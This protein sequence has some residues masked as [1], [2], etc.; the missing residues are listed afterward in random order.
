MGVAGS[1]LRECSSALLIASMIH[2]TF[3]GQ[4]SSRSLKIEDTECDCSLIAAAEQNEGGEADA[5][6]T[7]PEAPEYPFPASIPHH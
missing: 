3:M 4:D 7:E 2:Q 1:F 6:D 5:G